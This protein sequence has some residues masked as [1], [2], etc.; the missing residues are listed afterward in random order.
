M[1]ENRFA[2]PVMV[3]LDETFLPATGDLNELGGAESAEAVLALPDVEPRGAR[4]RF[5]RCGRAGDGDHVEEALLERIAR[6]DSSPQDVLELRLSRG[7]AWTGPRGAEELRE[8]EW[9]PLRLTDKLLF[10]RGEA[11]VFSARK[12]SAKQA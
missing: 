9:M 11:R 1:E 6:L 8:E 4:N 5:V 7:R 3:R 12:R 10:V 2:D